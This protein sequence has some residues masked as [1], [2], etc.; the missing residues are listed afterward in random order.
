MIRIFSIYMERACEIIVKKGETVIFFQEKGCVSMI[1][2]SVSWGLVPI[3]LFASIAVWGEKPNF[4]GVWTMN[5]QKSKLQ[6][7]VKLENLEKAEFT[8]DHKEPNFHFSRIFVVRGLGSNTFSYELTTDGKEVVK[9]EGE[10]TRYSR[11][12]WDNDVLVYDV[13]I[14]TKKG[15]ATNKVRYSLIDGGKTFVAEEQF[16]SPKQSYDN[17]W[18]LERIK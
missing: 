16:R 13:R 14:V 6:I 3:F 17:L 5:K 2:Q 11:I 12:Y 7:K 1:K 4:T 18:V 15:E 8:I 9:Q 10:E